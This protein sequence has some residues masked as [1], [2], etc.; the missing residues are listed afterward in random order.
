MAKTLSPYI[1]GEL[2][3]LKI[4]APPPAPFRKS[5]AAHV[6]DISKIVTDFVHATMTHI[7]ESEGCP[8]MTGDEMKV[9]A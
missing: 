5:V 4:C 9:L 6:T 7:V 8:R 2:Q 3:R 1:L